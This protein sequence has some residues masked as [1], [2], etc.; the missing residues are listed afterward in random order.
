MRQPPAGWALGVGWKDDHFAQVKQ[1]QNRGS[2]PSAP[3]GKGVLVAP[4]T[5][6]SF[7]SA[8]SRAHRT[9][10]TQGLEAVDCLHM[11]F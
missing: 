11:K 6:T 10:M 8:G 3:D 2:A 7:V 9:G 4:A 5:L 1:P